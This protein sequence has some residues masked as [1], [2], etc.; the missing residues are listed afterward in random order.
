[1][2]SFRCCCFDQSRAGISVC[3]AD[4]SK[5]QQYPLRNVTDEQLA[6]KFTTLRNKERFI[7]VFIKVK[8]TQSTTSNSSYFRSILISSSA[9]GIQYNIKSYCHL[10]TTIGCTSLETI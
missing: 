4:T 2:T 1:M 7:A 5:M 9:T 6:K 8:Q 10:C 3:T